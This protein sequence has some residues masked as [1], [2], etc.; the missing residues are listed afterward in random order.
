MERQRERV[1]A[2]AGADDEDG[3]GEGGQRHAR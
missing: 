2:A 1:F 3:A